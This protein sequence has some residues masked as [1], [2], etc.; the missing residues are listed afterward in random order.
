MLS[1]FIIA[2]QIRCRDDV[3]PLRRD[4][5]LQDCRGGRVVERRGPALL[6]AGI[7]LRIDGPVADVVLVVVASVE[8]PVSTVSISD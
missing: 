2:L 1:S 8:P 5:L 3:E 4:S 6:Q 7:V